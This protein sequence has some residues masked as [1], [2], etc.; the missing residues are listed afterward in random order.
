M[1]FLQ[2]NVR[3]AVDT[4]S[5]TQAHTCYHMILP[6][7]SNTIII[8]FLQF[9]WLDMDYTPCG[10]TIGAELQKTSRIYNF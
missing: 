1:T 2:Q 4:H 5:L 3:L 6:V 7:D 10:V 8:V 9:K